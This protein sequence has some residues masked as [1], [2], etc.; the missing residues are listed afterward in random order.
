MSKFQPSSPH[1]TLQ[2][3]GSR[4]AHTLSRTIPEVAHTP[5]AKVESMGSIYLQGRLGN[6]GFTLGRTDTG[7][8]QVFVRRAPHRIAPFLLQT[9]ASPMVEDQSSGTQAP[10]KGNPKRV[11]RKQ[12]SLLV[13]LLF[14]HHSSISIF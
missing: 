2:N 1:S 9:V 4:R 10:S 8:Q 6:V 14:D 7:R 12:L 11:E 3:E 5:Q 13:A